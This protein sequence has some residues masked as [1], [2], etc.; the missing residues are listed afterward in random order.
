MMLIAAYFL[1]LTETT[2][3][4]QSVTFL[5]PQF[6]TCAV[7]AHEMRKTNI[8]ISSCFYQ[9]SRDF[10]VRPGARERAQAAGFCTQLPKRCQIK[11]QAV[12]VLE[13][14]TVVSQE[15]KTPARRQASAGCTATLYIVWSPEAAGWKVRP[16]RI[17]HSATSILKVSM[18]CGQGAVSGVREWVIDFFT[19]CGM[20]R[21]KRRE[22]RGEWK[23]LKI[24]RNY[25]S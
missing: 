24:L 2:R 6:I 17:Y 22:F 4:Q 19:E 10:C 18:K 5:E 1:L 15:G 13:W 12:S 3:Q 8:P 14:L 25:S 9:R 20:W 7:S 23:F 16:L 21:G 11:S